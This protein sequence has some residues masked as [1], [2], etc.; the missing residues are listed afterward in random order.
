VSG[1]DEFWRTTVA[2]IAAATPARIDVRIADPVARP[3]GSVDMVVTLRELL[4]S[5][6]GAG[7]TVH[8]TISAV[9]EGPDGSRGIRLWPEGAP[10]RFRGV[11][12]APN[13]PGD[14][15]VSVSSGDTEEADAA[16]A[17]AAD[18]ARAWPDQRDLVVA[19]ARAHGGDAF[20]YGRLDALP[21]ALMAALAPAP[22]RVPWYPMRSAWWIVPFVLALGAEWWWRRRRGLA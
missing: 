15:R 6:P 20:E 14:W 16:V 7:D 13:E 4:L 22:R 21:A 1:F 17:V 12:D 11:I 19:W 18:P 9:L 10:G 5:D 3:G 8:A 2:E